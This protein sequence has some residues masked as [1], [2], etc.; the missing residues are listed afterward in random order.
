MFFE[1]I[2]SIECRAEKEINRRKNV[3]KRGENIK[4]SIDKVSD[5][6]WVRFA[7]IEELIFDKFGVLSN[8]ST[9]RDIHMNYILI[10]F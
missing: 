10:T 8:I 1:I 6:D 7:K 3:C 9:I 4:L 5:L 2:I